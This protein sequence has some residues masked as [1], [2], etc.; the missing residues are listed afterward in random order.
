MP[1]N[2][3]KDPKE[4]EIDIKTDIS[5][6]VVDS[7]PFVKN[8]WWS[9]FVVGASN[10][11]FDMYENIKEASR[12]AFWDTSSITFLRRQAGWYGI[13]QLP[14]TN[15]SGSIVVTGT[16]GSPIPIDTEWS[17]PDSITVKTSVAS[18]ITAKSVTP[19]SI[20]SVGTLATVTM[21]SPHGL[22]RGVS[23]T[24]SGALES[25]YNGTFEI[26][27]I[28]E[29]TFTYV[30]LASTTSPATG[31]LLVDYQT[32]L[33][34]ADALTFS[35]SSNLSAGATLTISS[36][37]PGIDSEAFVDANA[38]GGGSDLED[39]EV[40]RERF[41]FTVRNPVSNFNDSAIIKQSRLVGGV[42][43]VFIKDAFPVPGQVTISPLFD[44]RDTPIPTAGDLAAVKD[45]ILLIKPANTSDSN[46][47]LSASTPVSI[48]FTFSSIFPDTQNIRDDIQANLKQ[49][50]STLVLPEQDV[51]EIQYNNAI[52]ASLDKVT[53]DRLT[54]FTLS[55]PTGDISVTTNELGVLGSITFS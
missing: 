2:L 50:F 28:T 42:T 16:L 12:E 5:R 9:A 54:S 36:G 25:D 10:R 24:I 44:N 13:T 14:A 21:P 40:F 26:T 22:S 39:V 35:E 27:A 19:S 31:A 53:L 1:L 6:E 33:I 37:L 32:A 46:V 43:R 23:V 4:I 45:S 3:P 52:F 51:E 7:Q 17:T 48:D 55:S 34:P 8:S 49:F 38:F 30:I 11:F 20:V 18:T 41:L 15:G 47:I 29:S